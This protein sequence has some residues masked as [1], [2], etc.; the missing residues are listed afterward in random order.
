MLPLETDDVLAMV[1]GEQE[2]TYPDN[3]L[4]PYLRNGPD[5]Q[6]V[7]FDPEGMEDTGEQERIAVSPA[8][9]REFKNAGEVR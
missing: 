1:L 7:W 8:K 6:Y 4:R 3:W 2:Y 9:L 5:N